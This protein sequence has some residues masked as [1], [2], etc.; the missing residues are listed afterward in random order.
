[1][2]VELVV[3]EL[4]VVLL[5]L[6][7]IIQFLVQL[8]QQVVVEEEMLMDLHQ[9]AVQVVVVWVQLTMLQVVQVIHLP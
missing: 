9:T 7:E 6:Q 5:V 3:E 4:V 8:H 1:V 2:Q